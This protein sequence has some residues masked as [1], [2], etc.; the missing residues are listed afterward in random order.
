[1][2]KVADFSCKN[3]V[4]WL[5]S[6]VPIWSIRA[7]MA[8]GNENLNIDKEPMPCK[9]VASSARFAQ[10][11]SNERKNNITVRLDGLLCTQTIFSTQ[12]NVLL[13][14]V[15]RMVVLSSFTIFLIKK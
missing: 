12:L 11:T 14:K 4:T 2:T 1:M 8:S 10:L 13:K 15:S 5:E 3:A 6:L 9:Q 7:Y